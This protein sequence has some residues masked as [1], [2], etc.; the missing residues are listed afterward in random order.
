MIVIPIDNSEIIPLKL[1]DGCIL[2]TTRAPNPNAKSWIC[3]K[4]EPIEIT[5][6][7]ITVVN[8]AVNIPIIIEAALTDPL[9]VVLSFCE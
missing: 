8:I 3:D 6:K 5:S 9:A 1:I 4:R 7:K 2:D